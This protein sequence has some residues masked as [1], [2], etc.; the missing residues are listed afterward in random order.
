MTTRPTTSSA[1]SCSDWDTRVLDDPVVLDVPDQLPAQPDKLLTT[2]VDA[3]SATMAGHHDASD[4]VAA[5]AHAGVVAVRTSSGSL[6][7]HETLL[8]WVL[9]RAWGDPDPADLAVA[10]R[11]RA[12][13]LARERR[14]GC[15]S[16]Q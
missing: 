1:G 7:L 2:A 3:M 13:Q 9:V 6:E 4:H 15:G 5:L 11:L 8:G 12:H 10:A 16:P 14:D